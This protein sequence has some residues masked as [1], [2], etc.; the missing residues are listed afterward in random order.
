MFGCLLKH[1]VHLGV[2]CPIRRLIRVSLFFTLM[3][4]TILANGVGTRF[5][6]STFLTR[7]ARELLLFVSLIV[8]DI[9]L[10]PK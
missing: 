8:K 6:I 4:S 2:R 10:Y 1:G 5:V 9:T 7:C 3:H